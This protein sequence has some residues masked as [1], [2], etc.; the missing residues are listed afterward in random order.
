MWHA[1]L[2]GAANR[3]SH[4]RVSPQ[5][6]AG[7]V[8]NPVSLYDHALGLHRLNPDAALPQ[9][10]EPYPDEDQHR[11]GRP[12]APKDYRHC[13]MEAAAILDAYFAMTDAQPS[14]LAWAFHDVYV[15]IQRNE[16]I[17]AAA[18]RADRSRVR[19]AGRWLVR[20]SPDRCSAVVG[21]ALLAADWAEEDV[22]LIK[23]IGLLSDRFCPLAAAALK[24]RRGG[25]EALL[26]LANRVIGW[27]RVYV[28]EALCAV[29]GVAARPW[30]L[31][32]ACNGDYLN[33][34]FAGK[35]AVAAHVHEAIIAA[36]VDDEVIDHTGRLLRIMADA[37]GIGVTWRS[38][39]P[40]GLVL[41]AHADHLGRQAPSLARYFNA[42]LIADHLAR[43][44]PDTSCLT[45]GLRTQLL[46]RYLEVLGRTEWSAAAQASYDPASKFHAWFAGKVA[47]RLGLPAF[48]GPV[49]PD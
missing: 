12:R 30:L 42:A 10:G 25:T 14:D 15:P 23:I 39:P 46:D 43:A 22:G 26:W 38:Y 17:A 2:H 37:G 13:G 4:P 20:H 47:G 35:V 28:V 49:T 27:G 31:R 40:I 19:L 21:L 48:T 34:Y 45:D 33:G 9:D 5:A 29:G 11:D 44:S 7:T 32:R 36:D 6:G 16:H 18:L 1:C 8:V 3:V 24:R 41:D